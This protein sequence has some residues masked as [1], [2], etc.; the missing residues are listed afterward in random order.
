MYLCTVCN[1][2]VV[3]ASAI[4][5]YVFSAFVCPQAAFHVVR[6]AIKLRSFSRLHQLKHVTWD[7]GATSPPM[8][9]AGS[10]EDAASSEVETCCS[11]EPQLNA[12][13]ESCQG[14]FPVAEEGE[15]EEEEEV[16]KEYKKVVE[17]VTEHTI[18]TVG[19]LERLALEE[20]EVINAAN[21]QVDCSMSV[22][23]LTA[24]ASPVR[25]LTELDIV[26]SCTAVAQ[27]HLTCAQSG[28]GDARSP[29][30]Q[31]LEDGSG[32][33][34]P[35]SLASA[36]S[37]L[38]LGFSDLVHLMHECRCNGGVSSVSHYHERDLTV[39][40]GVREHPCHAENTPLEID[41]D[42][43]EGNILAYNHEKQEMELFSE[44]WQPSE[45]LSQEAALLTVDDDFNQ[46][47]ELIEETEWGEEH[48]AHHSAQEQL[49]STEVEEV[50][51]KGHPPAWETKGGT[52]VSEDTSAMPVMDAWVSPKIGDARSTGCDSSCGV[53]LSPT[54]DHQTNALVLESSGQTESSPTVS[55]SEMWRN[56]SD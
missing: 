7:D 47:R 40:T 39:P 36:N 56:E 32:L 2:T 37:E 26:S 46:G 6:F 19:S 45:C 50:V 9:T 17:E 48:T 11:E 54:K 31:Q 24:E 5:P 30:A 28:D 16:E 55:P 38:V 35:D 29:P 22:K 42:I 23:Q 1:S 3:S 53:L 15:T 25:G 41:S 52:A 44:G 51:L 21:S 12:T 20:S 33:G 10:D 27:H 18:Q 4:P 34:E 14:C 49:I 43:T 8:Q 13:L